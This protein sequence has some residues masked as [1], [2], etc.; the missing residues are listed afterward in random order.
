[1]P[2]TG[3]LALLVN[4]A[5]K[6]Y[7]RRVEPG[8]DLHTNEGVLEMAE[9][10]R[11]PFGGVARTRQGRPFK[12][13]RPTLADLVMGVR[14]QTQILYPKDIGYIC[15]RLGAGEGRTI[16]EAGTGSGSLTVALSW[17]SGQTGQVHTYEAR[18]EFHRLA[19][20]NLE[21]AGVGS[22]VVMHC[23]DIAEGFAQTGADAL[24]LDVRTPWAYLD[25]ALAAVKPGAV[26]GFLVPTV[27]QANE[28]L[29][30]F[31]TRPFDDV[32]M[33]EIFVRRWKPLA[34]R[35]R[36]EDRMIAH[37]G[38]LLFARVQET[39]A[40]WGEHLRLGTRERKQAAARQARLEGAG[41]ERP[42]QPGE[43]EP[44]GLD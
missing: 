11:V 19:R 15:M 35:L 40:D 9:L 18:P 8:N 37:T 42:E 32:E 26:M 36:P 28:L 30:A 25:Q 7:L 2:Q 38:F 17:F 21:W 13:M 5:G 3:E 1:M 20:R 29:T 23:R 16:I 22:N 44:D 31:E 43:A 39:P 4:P 27:G 33:S 10:A 6:R 34:D 41:P 14:R 12:V 24:F